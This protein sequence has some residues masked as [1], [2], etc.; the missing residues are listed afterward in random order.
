MLPSSY[1]FQKMLFHKHHHS[2]KWFGSRSGELALVGPD[3]GT[4]SLQSLSEDKSLLAGRAKLPLTYSR[5]TYASK[6]CKLSIR[7]L[8]LSS[9]IYLLPILSHHAY[10]RFKR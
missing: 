2:V 7:E 9:H 8:D 5:D 3:L 10:S 1:F 6:L 4:K